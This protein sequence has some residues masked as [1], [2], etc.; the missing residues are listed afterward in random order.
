LK[1]LFD[2]NS[3]L[4]INKCDLHN[5]EPSDK[6][7]KLNPIFISIKKNLNINKLISRIKNKLK[8][9]FFVNEDI[10]ITR[11]RHRQ[12]LEKCLVNLNNFIKKKDINDF[13]K[14]AEDLR[15]ATRHLGAIVGKVDVEEI[16]DSIFNDF[17][18]GK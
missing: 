3:I 15:I 18:I 7:K 6:I 9:K 10:L 5:I 17:C 12:H 13:D 14:S 2:E 8:N 16:L 4:I 11:V 1:D